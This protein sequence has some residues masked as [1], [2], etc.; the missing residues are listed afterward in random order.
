MDAEGMW[1]WYKNTDFNPIRGAVASLSGYLKDYCETRE[2]K[3]AVRARRAVPPL[4]RDFSALEIPEGIEDL[5]PLSGPALA[6]IEAVDALE[7]LAEHPVCDKKSL[8]NPAASVALA[9]I[10]HCEGLRVV[11]RAYDTT[12]TV[13]T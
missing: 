12:A 9:S 6:L 5:Q 10:E 7:T 4:R 8:V 2:P 13:A 1:E 11:A 3:N